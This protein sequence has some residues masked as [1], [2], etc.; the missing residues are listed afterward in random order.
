MRRTQSDP[1]KSSSNEDDEDQE[2]D[3]DDDDDD[4]ENNDHASAHDCRFD[5]GGDVNAE[6][7][8]E[9][10]EKAEEMTTTT[11]TE[12]LVT[13][14]RGASCRTSN[15]RLGVASQPMIK[16]PEMIPTRKSRVDGSQPESAK[17]AEPLAELLLEERDKK[18]E[19][20]EE[21]EEIHGAAASSA[22][23]LTHHFPAKSSAPFDFDAIDG[24]LEKLRLE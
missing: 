14:P 11:T 18:E 1:V 22:S 6:E 17:T 10:E 20:E 23:A 2:D 19:E 7:D 3:R 13:R 24:E 9:E 12:D 8:V 16:H 4:G 21:G 15:R 5:K